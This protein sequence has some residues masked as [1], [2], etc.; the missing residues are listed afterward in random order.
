MKLKEEKWRQLIV[1]AARSWLKTAWRH[2]GRIKRNEQSEGGVD[3]GGLIIEVGNAL[4]L[5]NEPI[6]FRFYSR[7]PSASFVRQACEAY[8]AP[9]RLK[10]K[11]P[12]DI[13]LLSN[14]N[15]ARHLAIYTDNNTI[16]HAYVPV[17]EVIEQRLDEA[18]QQRLVAA[19]AYPK[20][21]KAA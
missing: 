15:E 11:L 16:I 9:K 3:C 4:S 2:R 1:D 20:L 14:N 18:W 13:L 8:L 6:A 21:V 12:G 10:D 17:R 19:F 7:L 5:F